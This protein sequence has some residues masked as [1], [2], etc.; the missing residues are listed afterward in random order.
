MRKPNR[1]VRPR[2]LAGV[3][4]GVAAL[5]LAAAAVA[6]T[7]GGADSSG[8]SAQPSFST[9]ACHKGNHV[10]PNVS[11]PYKTLSGGASTLSGA[12]STFVAPVLSVWTSLYAKQTGVQVAYQ[13]IGSGGGV[14][15][16]IAKTVDFGDSDVPMTD[17]ELSQAGNP[18]LHI[19]VV[20]GAVVPAYNL[21][22][23]GSGLK[24][25]GDVLGKIFA[26]KIT[27][28]NDPALKALN[29]GIDLPDLPI[30]VAHRSD[31][32]GTTGVWT[33]FLT[34]TSPT[35]VQTLGGRAQ[36]AAKTVAWPVGI[37]GK[38]N[39]GVSAVVGQTK[40]ALGYVELQ[41]A[42][43]QHLT[44]GQ[45]K[46]KD[47][48]YVQACPVTAYKAAGEAKF[49]PDLRG[50][51]TME[52][53][54]DSYPVAG[55][56]YMLV[57]KNQTDPAKAKALANFLGWLLSAGQK[58]PTSVNYAPLGPALRA[59]SLAQVAKLTLNGKPFVKKK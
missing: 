32:S 36:S 34:K 17:S 40:G 16:I 1:V 19:P 10:T 38:G 23:L 14:A 42:Y 30:A 56:T 53:G 50:D 57:Y 52:P 58:Y 33:T 37:G 59:A 5:T 45:V 18:I 26:G 3:F 27:N 13:S 29:P 48:V 46:N 51:L 39:E 47:G 43:S 41:Y 4:A 21:P 12:G 54:K 31:G 22:G 20:L 24:F 15:Q 25:T 2:L 11:D 7:S 6:A 44:Y 28:W 55:T 8:R 35:W 9:P 49:P